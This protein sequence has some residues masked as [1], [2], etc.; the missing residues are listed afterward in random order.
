MGDVTELWNEG[1]HLDMCLLWRRC[2]SPSLA[3]TPCLTSY[4]YPTLPSLH[5]VDVRS[6]WPLTP[7]CWC[8]CQGRH[9]G[10]QCPLNHQHFIQ[11]HAHRHTRTTPPPLNDDLSSDLHFPSHSKEMFR[12]PSPTP[13]HVCCDVFFTRGLTAVEGGQSYNMW[14][15]LWLFSK[16]GVNSQQASDVPAQCSAIPR[17]RRPS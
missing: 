15:C 7:W 13:T 4:F 16:L 12:T 5:H 11:P 10:P 8:G 1:M 9:K 6:T 17:E 3:P 2:L 14:C